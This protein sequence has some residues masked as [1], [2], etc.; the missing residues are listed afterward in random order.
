MLYEWSAFCWNIQHVYYL[1]FL[2]MNRKK[3]NTALCSDMSDKKALLWLSFLT[4]TRVNFKTKPI[5]YIEV[6]N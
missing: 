4:V 1:C 2:L 6:E 3:S 5:F